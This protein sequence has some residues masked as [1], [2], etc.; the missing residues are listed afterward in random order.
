MLEIDGSDGGGQ[1]VRTALSLST[2][3]EQPF[4]MDG[5]RAER[6]NPGLA[7]QHVAAVRT[8]AAI[9]DAEVDG[10]EVGS[11][12]MTFE[13]A[14]IAPG[15]YQVDIGTAGSV[16]LLF[17]AV[18]P[19]AVAIEGQLAVAA[20]GGT[21]V[22][23]SPSTDWYREVKLPLLRRHGVA[24]AL[25]VDRRGF[26]PDGGGEASLWL[27]PS[28]VREIVLRNRGT[29]DGARVYSV[30]SADLDDREVAERQAE[31]AV[32]G[33]AP[34]DVPMTERVVR[35]AESRSTGSALSI[36]LDCDSPLGFDALGERGKPAE[37]VAAQAVGAVED[38]LKT[39]NPVDPHL[40][41]QLA[42]FLALGGGTVAI[43]RVTDHV[44]TTVA[45]V[46]RFGLSL[47]LDEAGRT[48]VLS[49]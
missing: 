5:I 37:D 21:D 12:A 42:V 46:E 8:L 27:G 16:T 45:L 39:G 33:L 49:G 29:V 11:T 35:Y 19:L 34:L 1:L 24:V 23:W 7:A 18:L 26:Y 2:V 31:A 32:E 22:A 10:V 6:P 41:D 36:L 14:T 47:T 25:D 38:A 40:A 13:P 30:A 9:T 28:D 4:R 15:T 3:T 44:E 43:P 17:D 20:R 48:P